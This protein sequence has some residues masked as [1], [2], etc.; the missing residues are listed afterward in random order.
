MVSIKKQKGEP[1]EMRKGKWR[2]KALPP[3]SLSAAGR[4][5]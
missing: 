4:S 3:G 2:G 5:P 1:Q